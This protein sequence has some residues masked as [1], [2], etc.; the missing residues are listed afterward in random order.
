MNSDQSDQSDQF[1]QSDPS[2]FSQQFFGSFYELNEWD[3]KMIEMVDEYNRCCDKYDD[4]ICSGM[5]ERGV[6][7]PMN[8]VEASLININ[9]KKVM[10]ALRRRH[11]ITEAQFQ[12]ALRD[13]RRKG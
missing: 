3:K 13:F 10:R 8:G 2:E 7:M 11:G 5:N 12:N 9:A 1:D 4:A 6:S